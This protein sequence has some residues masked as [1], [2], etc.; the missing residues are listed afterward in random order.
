MDLL[1]VRGKVGKH[2][3]GSKDGY[4]VRRLEM[5]SK[6]VIG[7]L[8]YLDHV[9][10]G[11]VQVVKVESQKPSGQCGGKR[12]DGFSWPMSY[13]RRRRWW[14]NRC[15]HLKLHDRLLLAGIEE[16]EVLLPKALNRLTLRVTHDHPHHHQV[17]VYL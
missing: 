16:L 8:A 10:I 15:L 17:T 11:G 1:R 7:S 2:F 5:S 3:P 6:V 14:L 4:T 9:A 13:N 12:C